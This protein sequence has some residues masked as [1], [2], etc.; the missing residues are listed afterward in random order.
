MLGDAAEK[1]LSHKPRIVVVD[2]NENFAN[3][4]AAA[5]SAENDV[6]VAYDGKQGLDQCL[7]RPA[8]IM[9]ADVGMPN[10][11]GVAMLREMKKYPQ[12]AAMP[13]II[14][15]ATHFNTVPR[16]KF[17]H[18]P[19]VRAIIQKPCRLND[20]SALVQSILEGRKPQLPPP[21]P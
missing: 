2:D 20:L 11:D 14:L 9:I 21:Y 7:S 10:M 18:D 8:D 17:E 13:V 12:I 19:Q 4:V 1:T 3:M 16:R 5:L 15:T 6:A